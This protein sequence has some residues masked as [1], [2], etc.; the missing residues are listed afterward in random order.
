MQNYKSMNSFDIESNKDSVYFQGDQTNLFA[1]TRLGFVQKVYGILT[2]QLIFT[3]LLS[4]I[5]MT[6]KSFMLF[7]VQN[8]GIL[9]FCIILTLIIMIVLFCYKEASRTTPYNY[10][11]LSIFTVCESWIVS[12]MCG[13]TNPKIV[14][15]ATVM[16]LGIVISLTLYAITT[17][18][19]FTTMGG[20]MYVLG[21]ALLLFVL[22]SIFSE[23]KILHI[24]ISVITVV[25]FG[26]Y[27]IYDTQLIIGSGKH[28]LEIDD[29]IV[30]ALILYMDIITLFLELLSLIKSV[31]GN[32]S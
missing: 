1:N 7:Q 25:I 2:C 26:I 19:D 17:K 28:G 21:M 23:N 8:Y 30:G 10:I 3:V 29:Y 15:M 31:S 32:N 9:I 5:S 18:T 12:T 13:V 27:L 20:L 22:F 4:I 16:T 24:I 14:L 6:S 11:L